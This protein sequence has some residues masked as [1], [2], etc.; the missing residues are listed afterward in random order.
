MCKQLIARLDQRAN[1]F[2]D[3][4]CLPVNEPTRHRSDDLT[5]QAREFLFG[6]LMIRF[7]RI[8]KCIDVAL[9]PDRFTESQG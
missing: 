6:Q 5:S 1:F 4:H 8:E 7:E 3:P 2:D 9:S